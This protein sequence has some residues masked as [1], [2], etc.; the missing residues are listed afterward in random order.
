MKIEVDE[1]KCCG[2]GQCALIAPEVFAQ[3][4]D[5]T[6]LLL[7]P[8]PDETL[9]ATVREAATACPMSAITLMEDAPVSG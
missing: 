4:D 7:V 6:V 1:E 2:A 9:H 5:R 3:R 8:V